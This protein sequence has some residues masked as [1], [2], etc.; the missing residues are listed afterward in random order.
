MTRRALVAGAA[1]GVSALAGMERGVGTAG[2][3]EAAEKGWNVE[4][5]LAVVG[6][7]TA[8]FGAFAAAK[9]GM[10]VVALEKGAIAGGTTI[11]SGCVCWVPNNRVM[12][13]FGYGPDVSDE[14]VLAYVQAADVARGADEE[15]ERDYIAHARDVFEWF[16]R[17][18]DLAQGIF[19][20][21]CDYYNL[22]GAMGLGRSIGYVDSQVDALNV[23]MDEPFGE[24]FLPLYDELGIDLRMQTQATALIQDESGRVVGVAA[25]DADGNEL[26]V[27]AEKGVLLG[28][29]GFEHNSE[30]CSQFLPGPLLGL[31]SPSTNTGDGIKMARRIGADLG[32]MSSIWGNPF[33]ISNE[34]DPAANILGDYGMYAGCPGA[35]YVNAAGKRFANE[36]V[37]YDVVTNAMYNYSTL[38]Y[39]MPNLTSWMVFDSDHVAAYGFPGF[40]DEQ[41]EWVYGGFDTLGELAQAC[42]I[43][44][45]GLIDEVARFN[46]F[47][48][49]GVDEDF[50]RGSWQHDTIQAALMGE[51]PDLANAALGPV[52]TPPFYAV[53][54]GPGAFGTNGGIRVDADARA[55]DVDGNVIDGLYACGNCTAAMFGSIYPGPGG[56]LG[57]GFYQALRAADHA[58]E[59]CIMRDSARLE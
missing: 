8:S 52:S 37:G 45:E 40:A 57:P 23:G 5:D 26:R 32:N 44:A 49:K 54:V 2:A 28:T 13:D 59:L 3:E 31:V 41:A 58:C 24:L 1:V 10:R 53:K 29:G 34:D 47:A 35:I 55:L 17:T 7:G 56:T 19:P 18:F 51:R 48:E 36:A 16:A 6:T 9:A 12:G 30:M 22:P 43:D 21:T 15:R 33:Y 11:M 27:R 42:G 14:E 20:G 4:A 50:G 46:G 38:T 39:S 25:K